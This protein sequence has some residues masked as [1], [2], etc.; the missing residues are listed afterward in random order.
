MIEAYP[1]C[2]PLGQKRTG[3]IN[4]PN[5]GKY[6]LTEVRNQVMEEIRA[7]RGTDVVISTNIPLRKDGL[8][9]IDYQRR[10]ITDKGVAVYFTL[11]KK[12]VVLACDKWDTIEHNL[13]AVAKSIEAM[14]GLGR[15]G[16]SEILDRAFTGFLALPAPSD[17]NCW[18]VLGI[19]QTKDSE[20]VTK[21]YR[22]LAIK[23]HPDN[24]GTHESM[25]ALNIAY[26]QALN[27]AK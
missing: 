26:T 13:R 25:T 19:D 21:A 15:W 7:M 17:N 18:S 8:P 14:R 3:V 5:F 22:A 9:H 20:A 24:G 2:W 23:A 1:L 12:P 4:T 11:N 16:V 27:F 10:S 6:T